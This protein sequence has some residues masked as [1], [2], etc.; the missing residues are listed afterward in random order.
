M[1]SAKSRSINDSNGRDSG[2]EGIVMDFQIHARI[3]VFGKN[4]SSADN[5]KVPPLRYEIIR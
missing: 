4:H 3:T 5:R 2:I 1:S